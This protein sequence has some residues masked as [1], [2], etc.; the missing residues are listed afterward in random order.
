MTSTKTPR[1]VVSHDAG[2]WHDRAK[3]P[4]E[5]FPLP[6]EYYLSEEWYERDLERILY[7]QWLFAGHGTNIPEPGDYF[8]FEFG[9]ESVVVARQEDGSVK[10]FYNV[11]R[12]RG[13]RICPESNRE[14]G[15]IK[16]DF[17]CPYHGWSYGLGGALKNAPK[18]P[19]DFD[20]SAFPLKEAHCEEWNSLIFLSFAETSPVQSIASRFADVDLAHYDLA[21]S[22]VVADM[23]YEVH[24]NW[25]LITENSIECYH[26]RIVHP[27]LCR[28]FDPQDSV[29]G[30][31]L[32]D[33]MA[34][35]A[36]RPPPT[37]T[38]HIFSL[39]GMLR[40]GRESLTTDGRYAVKRLLGDASNPPTKNGALF[41]FPNFDF[42]ILPDF[43]VVQSNLP[44]SPTETIFRNTFS[45]H[46]DAVEGE[47]YDVDD[48]TALLDVTLREDLAMT[49]RQDVV[50]SKGYEPGPYNPTHE[51]AVIEWMRTY[52]HI[53][54]LADAESSQSAGI[55]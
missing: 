26:C 46:R 30:E 40:P 6:G 4:L 15:H 1:A 19:E 28:V 25:K 13:M 5:F 54:A 53:H 42:G 37:E 21:N 38:Y 35:H 51:A 14:V 44:V 50:Q 18:M 48:L 49:A 55:E 16:K 7:R 10:A 2:S 33:R 36:D 3:P 41:A 9:T 39:E 8:V 23:T 20:K 22:K 47:D 29:V 52:H 24:A 17:V 27:E 45:V 12:H 34:A 43:F 31:K 32:T 11:C